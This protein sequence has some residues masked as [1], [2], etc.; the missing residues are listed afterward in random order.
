MRITWTSV[1]VIVSH[2]CVAVG[3]VRLGV[4]VRVRLLLRDWGEAD[5]IVVL[6]MLDW[7]LWLAG[8]M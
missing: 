2:V 1:G 6:I 5:V 7:W 8:L 3:L 4:V